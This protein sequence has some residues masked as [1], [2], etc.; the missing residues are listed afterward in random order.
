MAMAAAARDDDLDDDPDDNLDDDL[1][2]S[3]VAAGHRWRGVLAGQ[4]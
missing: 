4:I 3:T 1:V 2:R